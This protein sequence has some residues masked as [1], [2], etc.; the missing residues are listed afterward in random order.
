MIERL[1]LSLLFQRNLTAII[2][3][4]DTCNDKISEHASDHADNSTEEDAGEKD[5]RAV[6]VFDRTGPEEDD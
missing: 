3:V 2:A 5:G 6:C 1:R 4:I